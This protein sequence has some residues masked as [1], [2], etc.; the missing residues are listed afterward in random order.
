V[1]TGGGGCT[2]LA[3]P[4][5]PQPLSITTTHASATTVC[6]LNASGGS[7][8]LS[9]LRRL[10]QN[11]SHN[12][13]SVIATG[14]LAG[15]RGIERGTL[16][17]AVALPLTVTVTVKFKTQLHN[18]GFRRRKDVNSCQFLAPNAGFSL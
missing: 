13:S 17:T 10:N 18:S 14:T 12:K 9:R 6:Q 15:K 7:S 4:P 11:A 2:E 1:I 3:L 5:P 8:P 16:G